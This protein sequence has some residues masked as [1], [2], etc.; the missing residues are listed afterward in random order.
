MLT[1]GAWS[2]TFNTTFCNRNLIRPLRIEIMGHPSRVPT[3]FQAPIIH[4]I[5]TF[6]IW[7]VY[8]IPRTTLKRILFFQTNISTGGGSNIWC[9]NIDQ[10]GWTGEDF[11]NFKI[12]L[13]AAL[14]CP[15]PPNRA[16]R[17]VWR[18]HYWLLCNQP[19]TILTNLSTPYLYLPSL[20]KKFTFH[21]L[22][23]AFICFDY[24]FSLSQ[25][26]SNNSTSNCPHI[27]AQLYRKSA[28]C[29][30]CCTP[31]E[32][33][34]KQR[35]GATLQA[36]LSV[37]DAPGENF[38]L[39]RKMTQ[40]STVKVQNVTLWIEDVSHGTREISVLCECSWDHRICLDLVG[41]RSLLKGGCKG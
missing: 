7:K 20:I 22:P 8:D 25:Y 13:R 17:D 40:V 30:G 24:Y 23:L 6:H 39:W 19:R 29:V 1:C 26:H 28:G 18:G 36:I 4:I 10:N 31:W 35:V 34:T 16:R 37:K 41:S 2:W 9:A 5:Q 21:A 27:I 3:G 11:L 38:L 12:F 32:I 33:T 14:S 15:P